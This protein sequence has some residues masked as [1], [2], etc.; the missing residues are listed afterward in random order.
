LLAAT[1]LVNIL[2]PMNAFLSL[3]G[4]ERVGVSCAVIFVP[5]FFAGIVFGASFRDSLQ[6]DLDFGSNIAGAILG[7]LSESFSLLVGFNHMLAIALAFY[8]LSAVLRRS[9][10][11]NIGVHAPG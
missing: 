4:W 8:L 1:L 11:I 9:P 7:G 10:S 5:V 3:P 6:P 2:V